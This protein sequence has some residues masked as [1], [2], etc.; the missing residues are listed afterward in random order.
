M[1]R[2]Q[3]SIAQNSPM[4]T[5][6]L[7][8]LC[9]VRSHQ[10]S[11]GTL[12]RG[13]ARASSLEWKD[14]KNSPGLLRGAYLGDQATSHLVS[15]AAPS[16]FEKEPVTVG[17]TWLVFLAGPVPSHC[18]QPCAFGLFHACATPARSVSMGFENPKP[19]NECAMPL[20]YATLTCGS[21]AR[22]ERNIRG[23]REGLA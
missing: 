6:L 22:R 8:T 11:R 13:R 18:V 10:G 2:R 4:S 23:S 20:R 1:S 21:C 5:N 15:V 12:A 19:P 7:M 16:I 3:K 17:A 9:A 14:L